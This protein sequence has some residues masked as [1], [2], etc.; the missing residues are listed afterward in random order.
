MRTPADKLFN[1]QVEYLQ[2][3]DDLTNMVL[4]CLGI[5]PEDPDS[6][7]LENFSHDYYD[8]SFELESVTPGW[9]PTET[10]LKA[11]W[12]LGFHRCWVNYTD[13]TEKYYTK[14]ND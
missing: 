8:Y 13:G 4:K 12:K 11:C 3:E 14:I 2:L 7:P 10:Q 5:D 1:A 9:E 6:W